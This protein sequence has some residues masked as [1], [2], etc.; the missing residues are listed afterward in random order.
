MFLC[1]EGFAYT[2]A[3]APF[4]YL[5]AIQVRTGC[6]IPGAGGKD[7]YGCWEPNLHPLQEQQVL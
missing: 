7:A 4:V 3:C 1:D 5:A 6:W 2:N